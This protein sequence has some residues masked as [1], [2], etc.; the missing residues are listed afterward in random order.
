MSK[1]GVVPYRFVLEGQKTFAFAGVWEE[2]EDDEEGMET[3]DQ[4]GEEAV[5]H[6]RSEG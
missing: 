1:K 2:Y 4:V 6:E 3:D 5:G